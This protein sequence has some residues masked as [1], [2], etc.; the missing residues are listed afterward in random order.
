MATVA[1]Q[2][3]ETVET[4][5]QLHFLTSPQPGAVPRLG[6]RSG[7]FARSNPTSRGRSIPPEAAGR[8]G[9]SARAPHGLR[10]QS[11]AH[12]DARKH[13]GSGAYLERCFACRERVLGWDPEHRAWGHA[14]RTRREG[15]GENAKLKLKFVRP[16]VRLVRGVYR[17]GLMDQFSLR[18]NKAIDRMNVH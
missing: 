1:S 7:P 14:Q 18:E 5:L 17:E 8:C 10:V 2:P 12:L 9:S 15:F 3:G 16:N 4:T 11:A 13:A 6:W